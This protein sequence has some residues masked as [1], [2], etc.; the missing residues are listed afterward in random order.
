[1][2]KPKTADPTA[3]KRESAGRYVSGDGRFA[4]EQESAGSWVVVDEEQTN[5]LGLPLVRGPFGTLAE[6]K[7]VVVAAREGPA[8]ESPLKGRARPTDPRRGKP[9]SPA[10][11]EP[12]PTEPA[13]LETRAAAPSDAAANARIYNAGIESH[14]ATF[15]TSPRSKGDVLAWFDGRHPVVVATRGGEIV[16]FAATFEYRPREAYRGVAEFSV[17]TD[18]THRREGAGRLAMEALIDEATRADFWKLVSRVFP[19]NTASRE[20]LRRVGFRE[21]GTYRRHARL[22]GEWRDCVIVER[23]L[24]AALED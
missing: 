17:Y 16:A 4:V 23:L 18:A 8:P 9:R 2:P 21:V 13:P 20:L 6:A 14:E 24:G 1:M 10:A 7:N 15:E 11:K 19:Q 3:L 12:P 5:E 22:D